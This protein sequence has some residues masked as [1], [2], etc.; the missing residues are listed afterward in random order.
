MPLSKPNSPSED[1]LIG[2]LGLTVRICQINIE[3][4]SYSKDQYLSKLL[5]NDNI[6]IQERH[7]SSKE[8]T[9]AKRGR[10]PK[11]EL[12]GATYHHV[13]GVTTCIWHNIENATLISTS[14]DNEIHNVVRI[15]DVTISNIYRVSPVEM[16]V[17]ENLYL[18][19]YSPLQGRVRDLRTT[20]IMYQRLS[21]LVVAIAQS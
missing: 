18:G 15:G 1:S 6:A 2:N 5:K 3:I 16:P 20:A 19:L 10:I 13:Y 21:Q 4:I 17:W 12:L 9:T 14:P 8:G 7:C 11:Y